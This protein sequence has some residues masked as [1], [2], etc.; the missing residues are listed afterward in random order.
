MEPLFI[1]GAAA[2]VYMSVNVRSRTLL[3][4]ATA[5]ILAYTA[6]FTGEHFADSAGWPLALVVIGLV[7]IA[8]SALAVRIDR[9]YMRGGGTGPASPR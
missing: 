2:F 7:M 8:L 1:G 9:R 4:V 5:A 3:F 6:Y